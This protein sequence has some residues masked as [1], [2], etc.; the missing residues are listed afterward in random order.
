VITGVPP[1]DSVLEREQAGLTGRRKL[2]MTFQR[3]SR[4]NIFQPDRGSL[5]DFSAQ[6]VGG[7]LGGDVSFT[8]YEASYS[9]Y[10]VVWP[11]W[12][13][14]T[15]FK[16]G[17]AEAFGSSTLVPS[18]DRLYLGGANTIRGV[19]EHSLGPSEGSNVITLFNQEFRWRTIQVFQVIPVLKNLLRT[20][21]LWQSVFFDMGNG[22]ANWHEVKVSSFA[23]AYGTGFQIMSP[24]GPI[25][26]DY[27][28][29]IKTKR[30]AVTHRWHFTIL[31]AF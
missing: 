1:A 12:I 11:G 28:R 22:F 10:Q 18:E 24:A 8:K 31:Y 7:F 23:F 13:S 16:A 30:Y 19:P 15:R 2:Y 3:D 25:R 6:Y 29:L 26:V 4:E 9:T 20:M 5:F 27:G 17:W 14:A 21:P